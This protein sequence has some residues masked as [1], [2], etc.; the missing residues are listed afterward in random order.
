MTAFLGGLILGLASGVV[1]MFFAVKQGW[2][3]P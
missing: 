2:V 1:G 3:K